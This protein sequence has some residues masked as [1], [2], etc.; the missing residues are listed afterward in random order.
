M[1]RD[2]IFVTAYCPTQQ[3][4]IR[5][6]QCLNRLSIEGFDLAVISHSPLPIDIQQKCKWYLYDSE[7]ELIW[8]EDYRHFE[9]YFGDEWSI[10]TKYFKKTPFY[11]LAIYRMFSLISKLAE[12]F[13]YTKIYHVEYDYIILETDIFRNHKIMLET[14]DSVFYYKPEDNKLILGGLKS[15]K[16]DK[17][18]DLF[19]NYNRD[20]ML[21][22]IKDEDLFPL[23]RFTEKIFKESGN[24]VF[25]DAEIIYNKISVKKFESQNLN[26]A[27][28]YNRLN[29]NLGI[30]WVNLFSDKLIDVVVNNT[31][32]LLDIT[33]KPYIY[34]DLG[35]ISE[36]EIISIFRDETIIY[37]STI[38]S[39]YKEKIKRNSFVT[40]SKKNN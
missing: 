15:F 22:R 39:E 31:K 9:W 4:L 3:Q 27:L 2:L 16:V 33:D 26:W 17:L 30:F 25:I 12:T 21:R 32:F 40:K 1:N 7:N 29:D 13:K 10:Q 38:S 14:Y 5:L 11:G 6:R 18:P 20:E 8:D 24:P 28:C 37:E 19:K 36:I 23:E 35:V 34:K